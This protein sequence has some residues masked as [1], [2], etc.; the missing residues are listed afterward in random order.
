MAKRT[1]TQKT[2]AGEPEAAEPVLH[3]PDDDLPE[4][5][6]LKAKPPGS[7][8]EPARNAP[9]TRAGTLFNASADA[10]GEGDAAKKEKPRSRKRSRKAK[11]PAVVPPL[12][13][14][15]PY[16]THRSAPPDEKAERRIL[17][18]V[19]GAAERRVSTGFVLGIALVVVVL[20]G[21]I[22]L[23]RLG[24]K[25]RTLEA[26]VARLEAPVPVP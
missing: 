2:V 23:V 14:H 10:A 1:R 6:S 7:R 4:R 3:R 19:S 24:R 13:E 11:S 25:V 18:A 22:W 15:Y 20:V 5:P 9:Q 12:G 21:G 16:A 26:R 17:A 8:Q